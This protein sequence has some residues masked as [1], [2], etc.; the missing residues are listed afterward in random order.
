M[1]DD[2][3]F[4]AFL[5]LRMEYTVDVLQYIFTVIKTR[6]FEAHRI[7]FYRNVEVA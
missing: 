1:E 5:K 2:K 7:K 4:Q 6:A 3:V